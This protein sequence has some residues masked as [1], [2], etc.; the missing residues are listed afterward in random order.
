MNLL[1]VSSNFV[2]AHTHT[3]IMH[4]PLKIKLQPW[5]WQLAGV[6]SEVH[7]DNALVE[8]PV[9]QGSSRLTPE[10]S[11]GTRCSAE[12]LAFIATLALLLHL[13][14]DGHWA[15]Q[16][17]L[18]MPIDGKGGQEKRQFG[19]HCCQS[20]L[21]ALPRTHPKQGKGTALE[22]V[23]LY[24]T[25]QSSLLSMGL[26]QSDRETERWDFGGYFSALPECGVLDCCMG[27]CACLHA[28]KP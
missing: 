4:E 2:Q 7:Q 20:T 19:D 12:Q 25:Y 8:G 1:T 28:C 15:V 14:W 23:P 5:Q 18:R 6:A 3:G 10:C 27:V 16:G 24:Q 17:P 26:I 13:Q 22:T 11:S 9:S 21:I